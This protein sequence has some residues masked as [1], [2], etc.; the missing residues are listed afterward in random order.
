[1]N[2]DLLIANFAGYVLEKE[3]LTLVYNYLHGG[4]QRVKVNGS[5]SSWRTTIQ[6]VSQGS[7]LGSLLFDIYINDLLMTNGDTEVCKYADYT[8][9]YAYNTGAAQGIIKLETAGYNSTIWFHNNYMK[10][11]AEKCCLQIF[12]KNRSNLSFSTGDE[13]ITE[14]KEERLLEGDYK[15]KA[16]F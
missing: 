13:V 2:D 16:Y 6:G 15:Y 11:N 7:V 4:R 8:A 12:G 1:M 3:A 9:Y 14:S 10:L 5:I